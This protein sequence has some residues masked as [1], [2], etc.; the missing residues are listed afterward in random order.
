M[1]RL[2]AMTLDFLAEF[3]RAMLTDFKSMC[4]QTTSTIIAIANTYKIELVSIFVLFSLL[5][6][7]FLL[8]CSKSSFLPRKERSNI[9]TSAHDNSEGGIQDKHCVDEGAENQPRFVVQTVHC[10]MEKVGDRSLHVLETRHLMKGPR[11]LEEAEK[12]RPSE[13]RRSGRA[14]R[15]TRRFEESGLDGSV[16]GLSSALGVDS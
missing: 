3:P 10:V 2:S 15:P 5:I 4:E 1:L 13:P 7:V 9:G 8:G 6:L 12:H 16:R 14:R 11:V